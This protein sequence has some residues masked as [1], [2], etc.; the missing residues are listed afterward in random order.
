MEYIKRLGSLELATVIFWFL[1]WLMNGLAKFISGVNIGIFTF[2]SPPGNPFSGALE[3]IGWPDLG[4]AFAAIA[5][6]YELVIAAVFLWVIVQFFM[7]T[8][9]KAR[10][11]WIFFGLFLSALIFTVFA[12]QNIIA[13]DRPTPLIWHMTF[14]AAVGVSWIVIAMQGIFERITGDDE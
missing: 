5:G 6:I 13:F 8:G 7:R 10:R 3:A 2:G 4:D 12:V 9:P 14:F 11:T 1:F